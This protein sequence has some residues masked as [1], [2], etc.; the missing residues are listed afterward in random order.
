MRPTEY[1]GHH[2]VGKDDKLKDVF[3]KLVY[4]GYGFSTGP[5]GLDQSVANGEINLETSSA[6][7]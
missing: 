3:Q 4:G 1:I 5:H 7:T 2:L 6:G